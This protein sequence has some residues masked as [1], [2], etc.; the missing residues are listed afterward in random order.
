MGCEAARTWGNSCKGQFTIM[1]RFLI[2]LNWPMGT[3]G[4]TRVMQGPLPQVQ[5]GQFI[6]L[7][8]SEVRSSE[9]TSHHSSLSQHNSHMR[10]CE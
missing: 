7:R 3:V 2:R 10:T 8:F 1:A 5:Q 9:I 4:L 6:G